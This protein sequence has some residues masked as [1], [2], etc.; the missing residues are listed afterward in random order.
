MTAVRESAKFLVSSRLKE[1]LRDSEQGKKISEDLSGYISKDPFMHRKI[2]GIL[3]R[4]K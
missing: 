2:L 3:Q 4:L 1:D